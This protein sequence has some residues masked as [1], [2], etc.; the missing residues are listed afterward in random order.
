[1]NNLQPI[2][3][4]VKE[5]EIEGASTGVVDFIQKLEACVSLDVYSL[6]SLLDIFLR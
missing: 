1:M 4:K 5:M 2:F 3:S 6:L